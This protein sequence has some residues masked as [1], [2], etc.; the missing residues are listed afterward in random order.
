MLLSN[1]WT[2]SS[3]SKPVQVPYR[4]E[5]INFFSGNAELYRPV[6]NWAMKLSES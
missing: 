4:E 6:E 1:V 5:N 3:I 2:F